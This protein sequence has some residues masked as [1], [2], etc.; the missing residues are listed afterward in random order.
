ML[1]LKHEGIID[2]MKNNWS[3][4]KIVEQIEKYVSENKINGIVTF[5]SYGV[6]GHINHRCIFN[7]LNENKNRFKDLKMFKL[8]SVNIFRKYIL[9]LDLFILAIKD[10]ILKI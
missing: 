3:Y 4:L 5:D 2:G 10:I 6:S 9:V 7:S 1:D 8:I